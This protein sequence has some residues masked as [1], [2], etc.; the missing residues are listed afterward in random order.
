MTAG[1]KVC[2]DGKK[3][4]ITG[5]IVGAVIAAFAIF[6]IAGFL[7]WKCILKRRNRLGKGDAIQA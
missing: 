1:F 2:S 5:Y 7:Y 3:K 6:L 4:N